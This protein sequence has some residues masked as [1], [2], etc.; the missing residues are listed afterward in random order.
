MYR[1]ISIWTHGQVWLNYIRSLPM[2]F[3]CFVI[4]KLY[5][6]LHLTLEKSIVVCLFL[7]SKT[8]PRHFSDLIWNI[9][10]C[11]ERLYLHVFFLKR[12]NW[13]L[14]LIL[15]NSAKYP[16]NGP[17]FCLGIDKDLKVRL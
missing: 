12:Q 3:K 5:Y 6:H 9:N 13:T 10:L 11:I 4:F 14:K 8:Q 2:G 1:D 7:A 15:K 17:S 16:Q